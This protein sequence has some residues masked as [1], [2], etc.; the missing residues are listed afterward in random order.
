M[1]VVGVRIQHDDRQL[2]QFGRDFLDVADAHAGVEQQRALLA[3]D[4]IADR[5]FGLMRFIDGEDAGCRFVDFEPG[6][7]DGN[8]LES[9]VFRARQRA[10]P[11]RDGC[12][13]ENDA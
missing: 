5:F 4:Q 1:I 8:A 12:L 11:V 7:A 3:D 2:R 10:A 9:F 13:R 6:I